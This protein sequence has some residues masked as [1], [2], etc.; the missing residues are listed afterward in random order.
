MFEDLVA[1]RA[2]V[3]EAIAV[4]RATENELELLVREHAR[5]VYRIAYSVSRNHQDAEDTT[6][7]TFLRVLRQRRK[8]ASVNDS[9]AWLARIAWRVA[10]QRN[11]KVAAVPFE[12]IGEMAVELRSRIASADEL[13]LGAEMGT[14]LESL[15]VMLPAKLRDP[16][17]LSTI[18]ELSRAE[19][20][21]MLGT[22]E[23]AVRSRI[24]RARQI[25]RDK[26]AAL[27]EGKHG[28]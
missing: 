24:F 13:V 16:L 8:L 19:I 10:I 11:K 12:D 21:L 14:L 26:L 7:E 4:A 20:A 23:A 3:S 2:I 5:L 27:L 18:E 1:G 6:Q 28:T 17:I 15:I 9:R 22:N 25:L